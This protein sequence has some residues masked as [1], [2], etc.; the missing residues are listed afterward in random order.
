MADNIHVL[1]GGPK[2][3]EPRFAIYGRH[4]PELLLIFAS[5]MERDGHAKVAAEAREA[6]RQIWAYCESPERQ[7]KVT[8]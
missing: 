1:F 6:A 3:D 7:A 4:A 2:P 8:R 5:E